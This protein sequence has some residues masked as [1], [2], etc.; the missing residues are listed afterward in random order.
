MYI[1]FFFETKPLYETDVNLKQ[2]FQILKYFHLAMLLYAHSKLY[3]EK[4][5]GYCCLLIDL[6]GSNPP[7]FSF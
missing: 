2:S 7:G 4:N 5:I 6:K 3:L 1:F